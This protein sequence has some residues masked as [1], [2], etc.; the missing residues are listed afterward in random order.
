MQI[1]S[2]FMSVEEVFY[3]SRRKRE[4]R[5]WHNLPQISTW[6]QRV[7]LSHAIHCQKVSYSLLYLDDIFSGCKLAMRMFL[8]LIFLKIPAIYHLVI[9][10]AFSDRSLKDP[11][12]M[13]YPIKYLFVQTNYNMICWDHNILMKI[14]KKSI[15]INSLLIIRKNQIYIF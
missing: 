8:N 5:E 15:S 10:I 1:V 6:T 12:C 9:C 7:L 3:L 4:W 11:S 14:T 2:W 13:F